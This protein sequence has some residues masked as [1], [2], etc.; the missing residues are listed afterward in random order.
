MSLKICLH[1]LYF[2]STRSIRSLSKVA[3]THISSARMV[4]YFPFSIRFRLNPLG[5]H[6][7]RVRVRHDEENL[8]GIIAE[9][10]QR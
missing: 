1:F 6:I 8:Y 7:Y 9:L 5:K 10:F 2:R 3:E 4:H